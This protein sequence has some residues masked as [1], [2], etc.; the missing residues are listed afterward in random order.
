MEQMEYRARQVR[1]AHQ[2]L[3]ALQGAMA[4]VLLLCPS[5]EIKTVVLQVA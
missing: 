1:W 5:P 2:D 3:P 4:R